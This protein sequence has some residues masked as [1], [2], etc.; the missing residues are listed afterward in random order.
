MALCVA[1]PSNMM[2]TEASG[3]TRRGCCTS[4]DQQMTCAGWGIPP[5]PQQMHGPSLKIRHHAPGYTLQIAALS[6]PP[7]RKPISPSPFPQIF[8]AW[9]HPHVGGC[10]QLQWKLY[11]QDGVEVCAAPR[12]S[13]TNTAR[14]P[15]VSRAWW[16]KEWLH[17]GTMGALPAVG[18]T[19]GP[20]SVSHTLPCWQSLEELGRSAWL[21]GTFRKAPGCLFFPANKYDPLLLSQCSAWLFLLW[22]CHFTQSS[23]ISII[24]I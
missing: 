14:V 13:N 4:W 23:F 6:R 8:K 15:D 16:L 19:K 10:H 12:S 18:V 17:I 9:I 20:Q 21:T 11:S 3:E 22:L 7:G 2:K 1:K 24:K 5:Q